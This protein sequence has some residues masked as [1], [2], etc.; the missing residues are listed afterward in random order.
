MKVFRCPN[1]EK[2]LLRFDL[3]GSMDLEIKCT[4]C[5]KLIVTKLVGSAYIRRKFTKRNIKG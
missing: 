4:R 5:S 2:V 1:C 3:K